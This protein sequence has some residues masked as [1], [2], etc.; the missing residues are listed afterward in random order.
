M[1][2]PTLPARRLLARSSLTLL[3]NGPPSFL[4]PGISATSNATASSFSTSASSAYPRD[5]NPRR[6][7]SALRGTGLRNPLSVSKLPIPKP[8]MDPKKRSKVPVDPDHPLWGFFNQQKTILST[9]EEDDAHGNGVLIG[10]IPRYMAD[11]RTYRTSVDDRGV[12]EQELGRLTLSLVG[13]RQG[14]E[15]VS[16]TKG[17]ENESRSGLRRL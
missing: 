3:G 5:K 17:R 15:C 8:V 14:K 4:L 11:R 2:A 13:V 7:I 9:P 16:D 1:A 12:K 10:L 6:G